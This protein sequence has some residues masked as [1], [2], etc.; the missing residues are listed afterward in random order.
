MQELVLQSQCENFE[1]VTHEVLHA[2]GFV[3]E[4]KRPDRNNYVT[5]NYTNIREGQDVTKSVFFVIF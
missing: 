3:H 2:L 1:V 5:V 4:H